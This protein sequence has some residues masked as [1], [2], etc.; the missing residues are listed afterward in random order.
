MQFLRY[1]PRGEESL[2]K[3]QSRSFLLASSSV[4]INMVLTKDFAYLVQ[5]I[6]E[7]LKVHRQNT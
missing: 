3:L 6:V 7:C 2:G 5:Q 1:Q 4:D